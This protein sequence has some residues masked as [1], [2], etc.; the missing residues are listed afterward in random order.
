[1][2]FNETL[3]QLRLQRNLTQEELGKATG[4]SKSTIGMYESGKR[5]PNFEILEIFAD[6]FNTDMNNLIGKESIGINTTELTPKNQR[7]IQKRLNEILSD[8]NS[9]A[10][11][12]FYNGDDPLDEETLAL[13][14]ASLENSITVAKLKAKKKFTPKKY[15]R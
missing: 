9:D 11:L 13:L 12:T 6:Y 3:K 4:L 10:A 7:D 5:K 15:Q 1:M 14:K 2:P 8:L